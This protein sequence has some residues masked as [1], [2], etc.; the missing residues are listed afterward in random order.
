MRRRLILI[1]SAGLNVIL[2]AVLL[3]PR[4]HGAAT[5]VQPDAGSEISGSNRVK[6]QVIV[7][8]QFF[9]WQQLESPD[10]PTYIAHLREIGCPEQT[11]RD[12]IIADVNQLYAKKRLAELAAAEPQWWRSDSEEIGAKAADERAA[13]LDL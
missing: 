10:Y 3:F 5:P 13:V 12:I 11:I 4:H 9:S 7:R 6:T 8:K 2:A 1:V